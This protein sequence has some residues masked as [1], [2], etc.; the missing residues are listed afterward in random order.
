MHCVLSACCQALLGRSSVRERLK[1]GI[2]YLCET[3]MRLCARIALETSL[4]A[5]GVAFDAD[6]FSP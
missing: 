3:R 5:A 4:G 6:G 1:V 2:F